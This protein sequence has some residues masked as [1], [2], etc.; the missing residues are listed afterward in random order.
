MHR[1]PLHLN[2]ALAGLS[3]ADI[4][5][6]GIYRHQW[7]SVPV[8]YT[9]YLF[10]ADTRLVRPRL[11]PGVFGAGLQLLTDEAGDG[12][13]RWFQGAVSVSYIIPLGNRMGLSAGIQG[14]FAQRSFEYSRLTF[15]EQFDGDQFNASSPTGE[16]SGAN[17]F[18]LFSLAAGAN[19]RYIIPESRTRFDIGSG[20]HHLL[21][22]VSSYLGDDNIRLTRR[23]SPYLLGTIQ[24][25][26]R[27]DLLVRA[28]W[29][30]Q[31]PYGEL[32]AGAGLAYHLQ[33]ARNR[34]LSLEFCLLDRLNDA[35]IP[36]LG[37]RYRSWE[38]GFSYDINLSDFQ[39]AT[40]QRGGPEFYLQ[41]F[42][43]R[44]QAPPVF[45]SCPIF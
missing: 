37:L 17:T 31:Q 30:S 41:Y 20:V 1:A 36:Q 39:Q 43:T 15:D 23:Y 6:G 24:L 32:V 34:E 27:L 16:D 9:T 11:G 12:A 45:K 33:T 44:V 22:P 38:A 8:P 42:I 26:P 40:N 7:Q 3:Q 14:S 29:Q 4:R 21:R 19:L 28:W 5:F 2:P 25:F 13:M 10:F 35:L 18:S